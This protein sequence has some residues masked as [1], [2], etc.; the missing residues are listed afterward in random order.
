MTPRF[1]PAMVAAAGFIVTLMLVAWHD[2]LWERSAPTP[3]VAVPATPRP[4]PMPEPSVEA[5]ATPVRQRA[6]DAA[7][8][9]TSVPAP[10]AAPDVRPD[11]D[12]P[13]DSARE[14]AGRER[15]AR[16]ARTR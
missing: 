4:I 14:P 11:S 8:S 6:P 7:P 1:V 13:P 15:Q 9:D 10:D 2:G 16:G 3:V 12:N 5:A